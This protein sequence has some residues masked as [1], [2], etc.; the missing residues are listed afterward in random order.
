MFADDEVEE[1][2]VN[3][4]H[5]VDFENLKFQVESKFSDADEFRLRV[6]QDII[7]KIYNLGWEKSDK[8]RVVVK[9]PDRRCKWLMRASKLQGYQNVFGISTCVCKKLDVL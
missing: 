7:M 4:V 2:E 6:R 1:A 5:D 8:S 3:E 9:C